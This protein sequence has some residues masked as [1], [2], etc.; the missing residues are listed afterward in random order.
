MT[1]IDDLPIRADKK[2]SDFRQNASIALSILAV[3]VSGLSY[4]QSHKVASLQNELARPLLEERGVGI[5]RSEDGSLKLV[6]RVENVGR[7]SAF[8]LEVSPLPLYQGSDGLLFATTACMD[9]MRA[10]QIEGREVPVHSVVAVGAGLQKAEGC[11]IEENQFFRTVVKY[12]DKTGSLY[13]QYLDFSTKEMS[14]P[15]QFLP[16]APGPS[17][18]SGR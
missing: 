17:S 13:T 7:L 4:W 3:V 1:S 2:K 11:R 5:M 14:I 8:M 10:S 12:R 6:M 15:P 18:G 9:A 16:S